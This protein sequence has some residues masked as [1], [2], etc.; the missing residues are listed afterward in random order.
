VP[1]GAFF[2][3]CYLVLVDTGDRIEALSKDKQNR[4]GALG[5]K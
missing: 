5:K 4:F 2:Y 3:I 1:V